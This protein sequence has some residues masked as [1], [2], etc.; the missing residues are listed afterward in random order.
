MTYTQ[1]LLFEKV[2]VKQVSGPPTTS[3]VNDYNVLFPINVEGEVDMG[4]GVYE[5]NNQPKKATFK[6]EKEGRF[7][8]RVAKLEST[9]DGTI[10][11]NLCAVFNYTGK[12]NCLDT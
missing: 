8:L 2:N 10:T 4:R 6:Y 9:E 7:F 12:K 3:R 1:L 5:T 11:R